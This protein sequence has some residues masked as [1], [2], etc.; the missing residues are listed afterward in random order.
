MACSPGSVVTYGRT[1]IRLAS[2]PGR[3]GTTTSHSYVRP[4]DVD[5]ILEVA[6][7]SIARGE[8][9]V[10]DRCNRVEVQVRERKA[11]ELQTVK[12]GG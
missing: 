10:I 7:G 9:K 4:V 11:M 3:S 12:V 2:T 6:V 1:S 8:I 5:M